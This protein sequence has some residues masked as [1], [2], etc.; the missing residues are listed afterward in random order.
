MKNC[1]LKLVFILIITFSY[2]TVYFAEE[3]IIT[4]A[5]NECSSDEK[6]ELYTLANYVTESFTYNEESQTFD[7]IFENG[8][9][10][11]YFQYEGLRVNYSSKVTR[12]RNIPEGTTLNIEVF[13]S[14]YT[15][16]LDTQIRRIVYTTPYVNSYL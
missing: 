9:P 16:C 15:S 6:I 14:E 13:A 3:E 12:L 10:Y 11:L 7:V 8:S 4:T 1:I 5:G 2:L